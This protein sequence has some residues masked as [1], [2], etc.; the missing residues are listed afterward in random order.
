MSKFDELIKLKTGT[1][2]L[3]AKDSARVLLAPDLGARVFVELDG[4]LQHRLD[5]ENVRQPDKPFNNYGGTSFWPAP[6]GG[7]FGFNYKGDT[8]YVQNGINN[9]PFLLESQNQSS[10]KAVK[11]TVLENRKGVELDILMTRNFSVSKPS[12]IIE[13][14]NPAIKFSYEVAD[15]IKVLND[16]SSN[17]ALLACWTLE[18]FEASEFTNSFIKVRNP[19]QAINFDFYEDPRNQITC[20]SKGAFYKTNGKQKGQIGIKKESMPECIGFYDLERKLLCT[21]EVVGD[22]AG[23][24][25]NIADNEQVNGP[26]SAADSYSIFNGPEEMGFFELETIG[27]ADI[28]NGKLK[29]S[30]LISRTS[31]GIFDSVAPIERFISEL[32]G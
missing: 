13:K 23:V 14:L 22:A 25:F 27:G 17:D 2:Y 18:Q 28:Q 8:W 20:G 26:F 19:M 16:I 31:F 5:I 7:K 3:Y 6:E 32:K 30:T 24:Y 10:A 12:Q 21:R 1:S 9:A 4:S 29:G 11:R 15:N